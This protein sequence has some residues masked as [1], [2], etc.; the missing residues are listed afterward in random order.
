MPSKLV[1]THTNSVP[2]CGT[3]FIV[4]ERST[5]GAIG[6]GTTG[7]VSN[8][9]GVD[10]DHKNVAFLTAVITRRG[11]TGK[12]RIEF[13]DISTPIFDFGNDCYS[14]YL[15]DEKRKQYVH[16][17]SDTQYAVSVL[18]MS[19]MDFLSW[20]LAKITLYNKIV[21]TANQYGNNWPESG[22][23]IINLMY[24]SVKRFNDSPEQTLADLCA[25]AVRISFMEEFRKL[26]AS[27]VKGF[28]LYMY[29]VSA[30]ESVALEEISS[31]WKK[32]KFPCTA[33]SLTEARMQTEY[34]RKHLQKM[35]STPE[36]MADMFKGLF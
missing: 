5:D 6:P 36:K 29:R 1:K 20:A 28:A 31:L 8:I 22:D 21:T 13:K 18:N 30:M 33:K 27:L 10:S 11:K 35:Y 9:I 2:C 23:N 17:E 3:K 34:R 16:I 14:K 26:E 19:D 7:V 24:S 25:K 15:P 32:N 4:S 12:R